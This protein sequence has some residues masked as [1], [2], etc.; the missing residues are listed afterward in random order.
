M[1]E[2]TKAAAEELNQ[3]H[4]QITTMM[5]EL[6]QEAT[7]ANEPGLAAF[8]SDIAAHSLNEV[9]ILEPATILIGKYL[10]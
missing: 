5:N 2:R 9:E 10:Q 4:V 1:A 8:A 3:E 7:R 6:R